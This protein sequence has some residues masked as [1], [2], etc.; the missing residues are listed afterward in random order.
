MSM[1]FTGPVLAIV[2]GFGLYYLYKEWEDV[3]EFHD[4]TPPAPTPLTPPGSSAFLGSGAKA[5]RHPGYRA[6]P[7]QNQPVYMPMDNTGYTG[8]RVRIMADRKLMQ[9]ND[10]R[11]FNMLRKDRHFLTEAGD[12]GLDASRVYMDAARAQVRMS[13]RK[14]DLYP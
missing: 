10:P 4:L 3:E 1:Q 9:L 8:Y 2:A 7:T 6:D 11:Y 12:N 13:H 5:V 14:H